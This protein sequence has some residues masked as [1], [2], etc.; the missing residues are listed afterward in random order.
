[1]MRTLLLTAACGLQNRASTNPSIEAV[2][3]MKVQIH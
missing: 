2:Q 1:M 3:D